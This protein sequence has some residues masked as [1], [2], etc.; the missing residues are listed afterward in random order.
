M[1]IEFATTNYSGFFGNLH[2]IGIV[3]G[4]IMMYL[5]CIVSGWQVLCYITIGISA[6]GCVIIWFVPETMP[7]KSE[8]RDVSWNE[9]RIQDIVIGMTIMLLQQFSGIGAIQTNLS[10]DL[11]KA[12]VNFIPQLANVAV[13]CIQLVGVIIAGFV[14]DK[15]GRMAMFC[16]S[17]LGCGIILILYSA[18][19]NYNSSG[20]LPIFFISMYMLFFGFALGP[21]PWFIVPEMLPDMHRIFGAACV[22]SI[23]QVG[24]VIVG[25]LFPTIK[26][27]LG[28]SVGCVFFGV[29]CIFCAIFGFNYLANPNVRKAGPLV[30]IDDDYD[31]DNAELTRFTLT[32]TTM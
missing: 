11:K 19:L 8:H 20:A 30:W 3:I 7:K 24:S 22:T 14:V 17:S 28:L 4:I 15:L 5:F 6:I 25:Y 13:M 9:D 1:L 27:V 29:M 2:Q 16:G 31:D 10:D 21:L 23:N 12:G 26:D 32:Q 18:I